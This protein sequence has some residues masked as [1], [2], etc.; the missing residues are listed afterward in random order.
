ML[1]FTLR[2]LAFMGYFI[3]DPQK[4]LSDFSGQQFSWHQ[5]IY[6]WISIGRFC[7]RVAFPPSLRRCLLCWGIRSPPVQQNLW[8]TKILC[9]RTDSGQI[10][11]L[12]FFRA[13]FTA[14]NVN[15]Q[16]QVYWVGSHFT[17]TNEK[18]TYHSIKFS[19]FLFAMLR[20]SSSVR[21]PSPF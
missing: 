20:N 4:D 3:S 14:W 17:F 13:N 16:T 6:P 10:C 2:T 19:S 5:F 21:R 11:I 9:T 1:N 12:T 8:S 15:L 7:Q 18:H